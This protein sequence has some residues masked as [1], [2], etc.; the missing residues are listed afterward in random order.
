MSDPGM[1]LRV[2]LI[3]DDRGDAVLVTEYL[4]EGLPGVQIVWARSVTDARAELNRGVDCVLLDLGLPGASGLSA[5][6]EVLELAH[7]TAVVVLTGLAVGQSGRLAVAAG[8]QDY[9]VKGQVGVDDLRRSVQYAIE[10]KR[11]ENAAQRLRESELRAQEYRRLERGLLPSLQLDSCGLDVA[12]LYRPGREQSLLGGDFYDAIAHTD[13]SVDVL[14]G[15]VAGHG[16][17]EAALGASLRVAWRSMVLAEV[18]EE[19]R[20][21]ALDRVLCSER[22]S[23]EVFATV[24]TLSLPPSMT[25][26]TLRLAG[27]PPPIQC[28]PCAAAV[29]TSDIGPALGLISGASYPAARL[30]LGPTW[31][32]LLYTD[33]LI[34]GHAGPERLGVEGLVEQ[35]GEVMEPSM[36]MEHVADKLLARIEE[37][38]GGPVADDIAL[39]LLRPAR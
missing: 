17:S 4:E 29:D 1:S 18:P 2:L 28:E 8:A 13:G 15:D 21:A 32:L 12:T 39:L 36:P 22:D 24:A 6:A 37:L 10:R 7:A 35:L 5:L 11:N 14:I 23:E 9:L 27:H 25:T 38:N 31:Q 30:P 20:L 16:P 3:E 33:G 19:Q 34:E 26:A